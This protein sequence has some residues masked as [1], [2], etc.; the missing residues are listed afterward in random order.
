M[1]QIASSYCCS[2][3]ERERV[4]ERERADTHT[5]THRKESERENARE[6]ERERA[7]ERVNKRPKYFSCMRVDAL[8]LHALNT[9]ASE[10]VCERGGGG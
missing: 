4:R 7:S 3:S 6:R 9:R 10:S 8:V 1:W 2:S 5:H